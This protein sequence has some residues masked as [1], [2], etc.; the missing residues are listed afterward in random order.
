MENIEIKMSPYKDELQI[1]ID[2]EKAGCMSTEIDGRILTVYY[3]KL[4][5]QYEGKGYAKMLLDN[6]VKY[7]EDNDLLIDPECPFTLQ[8]FE[9]N[10]EKY[11]DVWNN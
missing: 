1:W 11:K 10:P 6:L 3:T 2:G 5:P 7:A 8:Q 9:H 4:D